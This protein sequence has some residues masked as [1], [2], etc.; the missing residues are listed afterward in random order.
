MPVRNGRRATQT[1]RAHASLIVGVGN[2]LTREPERTPRRGPN[3]T[4]AR[5]IVDIVPIL[6]V[7]P[8]LAKS[9]SFILT[10]SGLCRCQLSIEINDL[11][12]T[13]RMTNRNSLEINLKLFLTST[14]ALTY[15]Y[16]SKHIYTYVYLYTTRL[17]H[18]ELLNR[19]FETLFFIVHELL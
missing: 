1:F 11:E 2:V 8:V 16:H 14:C 4:T 15:V 3:A 10:K 19:N 7:R 18:I 12:I 6:R 9:G 5:V 13:A 17:L